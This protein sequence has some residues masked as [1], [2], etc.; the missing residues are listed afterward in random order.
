MYS[1]R[2]GTQQMKTTRENVLT[3]DPIYKSTFEKL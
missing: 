1:F 2:N 3:L